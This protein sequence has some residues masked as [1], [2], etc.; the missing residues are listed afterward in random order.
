MN[1]S[2]APTRTRVRR[3]LAG[4]HPLLLDDPRAAWVVVSGSVYVFA[5][6]TEHGTPQGSREYVCSVPVGG[7][8]FGL[9]GA[10]AGI[11]L[12]AV[13][14]PGTVLEQV[15]E[16]DAHDRPAV[17]C[18]GARAPL[19]EGWVR[20]LSSAL[21]EPAPRDL[22]EL[23]AGQ[24]VDTSAD[25]VYRPALD[26]PWVTV[27]DGAFE[28]NGVSSAVID[29][30]TGPVPLSSSTWLRSLGA[31][32]LVATEM[33]FPDDTGPSA[34]RLDPLHDVFSA[35]LVARFAASEA[36]RATRARARVVADGASLDHGLRE[37][38]SYF[39]GGR[40]AAT[41]RNTVA[42]ADP[43]LAACRLV[44]GWLGVEVK[45]AP[46]WQGDARDRLAAIARASRLR[47]RAITLD[48]GWW[49]SASGPLLGFVEATRA[50]VALLPAP[51]RG[52]ELIEPLTRRRTPVTAEIAATLSI[53]AH[54]LYRPFPEGPIGAWQLVRFG[55]RRGGGDVSTIVAMAVL[56]GLLALVVPLT[57]GLLFNRFIPARDQS[58]VL[59]VA[60]AML[61][62]VL[63]TGAFQITR[64]VA[65]ARLGARMDESIE[66]A[67]WDRLLTLP[68]TFFRHYSSGD[69]AVRATSISAIRR[70]I[71]GVVV[72]AV[73]GAAFSVFSFALL[74]FYDVRLALVA[75]VL[76]L[77]AT[78]L[79]VVAFVI[80]VRDRRSAF[81]VRGRQTGLV[82]QMLNGIT[83]LRVAGAEARAF[84]VWAR[85]VGGAS[86]RR[87]QL[88]GAQ[89]NVAY[90]ALPLMALLVIFPTAVLGGTSLTAGTFLAFN[91]AFTQV[92]A[93]VLALGSSLGAV[94][95]MVPLYERVKPI[96]DAVPESDE[97]KADPGELRGDIEVSDVT[98]RYAADGP[99]VLD[100][101][102][103]R[104]RPGQFIA[105]VGP[106]GS[107]KSTILRLLLGF[108]RAESGSIHL[109]AQDLDGLD[110][111]AVRRQM[112]VVLQSGQLS[113]GSIYS[114]IVG[115]AP[116]TLD[117]A[118]DAARRSGLD[119]DI[120]A[121]PMGMHTMVMEGGAG[122][123][124]GQ[125]QRL[126]IARAIVG[127]PRI[128]LF[129]EATSALD[130]RTQ[131]VVTESLA[132][133][134]TTRVVIAHRLSTV[135]N[136][137]Q[138]HVVDAGRIVESGNY[139]ELMALGGV[140]AGLAAR[141]LT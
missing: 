34:V 106:S 76:L 8:L 13:G 21:G 115:S 81:D 19:I 78:A 26:L 10:E 45:P 17:E 12:L 96:L 62:A 50:P 54:A 77:L 58:G 74:F 109:D 32:R 123:S 23:A 22:R 119:A 28:L 44:G 14:R 25:L 75:A 84:S 73:L 103:F 46:A 131:A 55:L 133:L 60:I 116:F 95:Q 49:R 57:S 79:G 35:M 137:D 18:V 59:Q 33:R 113:P 71:S 136:A 41:G 139:Q 108:E 104:A 140:F 2:V 72:T 110:L 127:R 121:M 107:G 130:N 125:R 51:R 9:G 11:A 93:A 65:A 29:A 30:S 47:E 129:D 64:S 111:P 98:F 5:V 90:T 39:E 38:L 82:F 80:Q 86:A 114:N 126:L 112:G 52:Y 70:I 53:R 141:Q 128:L 56:G 122:L 88:T 27:T 85:L 101:V 15:T 6:R 118:W 83:K 40:T 102:S 7:A 105:L 63:A 36:A 37:L 16:P 124:G 91:T 43:L 1:E 100:Q 4:N 134:R 48:A 20:R 138:I 42:V 61:A 66:A 87:S 67:I 89:L 99:L 94:A 69:L 135:I 117:D 97:A 3:D 68:V 92:I 31:G 24:L 120:K 132:R